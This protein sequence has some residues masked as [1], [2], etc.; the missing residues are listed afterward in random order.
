MEKLSK[1]SRV[2]EVEVS[3]SIPESIN[4][5]AVLEMGKLQYLT[6]KASDGG[7]MMPSS[8]RGVM[9]GQ[10]LQFSGETA[11]ELYEVVGELAAEWFGVGQVKTDG[12]V[13]DGEALALTLLLET[14]Q[15]SVAYEAKD[16]DGNPLGYYH[17]HKGH[18]TGALGL[19]Y[20]KIKFGKPE[21]IKEEWAGRE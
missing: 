17:L 19:R 20:R 10:I 5:E 1:A 14:V 9:N 8:F 6:Q 11:D 21:E 15:P 12:R 7:N 16:K 13:S 18:V 4:L 2:V 3:V